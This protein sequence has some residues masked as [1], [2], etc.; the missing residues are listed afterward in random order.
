MDQDRRDFLQDSARVGA[1]ALTSTAL[2]RI[3]P[4]LAQS[5]SGRELATLSIDDLSHRLA[6]LKITSRQ[7]VEQALAAIKDPQGEGSRTFLR[8]HES[9]ALA[10]ADQVDARRRGGARSCTHSPASRL[11]SRTCSTKLA[12]PRLAGRKC[13]LAPR[14]RHATR[15]SSSD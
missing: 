7:L 8:V 15:P 2:W 6:N 10:A 12:S 11:R 9:E 3:D 13:W 5:G 1:F 14:R 4:A